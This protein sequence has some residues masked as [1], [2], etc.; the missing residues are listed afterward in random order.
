[1]AIEKNEEWDIQKRFEYTI[2]R[3]HI[4]LQ[5]RY[6]L[7]I[8]IIVLIIG[9]WTVLFTAEQL[10]KDIGLLIIIGW[11]ISGSLVVCWR[12]FTHVIFKEELSLNITRLSCANKLEVPLDNYDEFVDFEDRFKLTDNNDYNSFNT[13]KKLKV[14]KKLQ[15]DYPESGIHH[16]DK[17]S[18]LAIMIAGFL[19]FPILYYFISLS[20]S[21]II[22]Y[23]YIVPID[24]FFTVA[25]SVLIC[26][27]ISNSCPHEERT[28]DVIQLIKN[29]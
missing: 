29:E 14:M 1:M 27:L 12:Y 19:G 7:A 18:I 23:D 17:I 20:N 8:A 16:F 4:L 13:I 2:E 6:Q 10:K 25:A 15:Y 3:S 9:V 24:V 5:L 26:C 11:A 28:N 21:V 22:P